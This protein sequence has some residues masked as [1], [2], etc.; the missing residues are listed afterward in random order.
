MYCISKSA[1]VLPLNLED[2]ARSEK[3]IEEG[4][5]VPLYCDESPHVRDFA[6]LPIFIQ[7]M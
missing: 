1:A 4:E 2:A 6:T 3:D 5:K 7:L